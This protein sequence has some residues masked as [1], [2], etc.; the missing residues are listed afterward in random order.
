[1]SIKTEQSIRL[2]LSALGVGGQLPFDV[3]NC[4][5]VSFQAHYNTASG[6]SWSTAVV[7]L[8]RSN[9]TDTMLQAWT[10]LPTGSSTT[11]TADGTTADIDVST[12]VLVRA[13]VSTAQTDAGYVV[14]TMVGLVSADMV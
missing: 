7:T 9:Q 13:R 8:E 4:K 10:A 5:T 14:I 6:A 12:A 1:M 2:P 11:I 3:R